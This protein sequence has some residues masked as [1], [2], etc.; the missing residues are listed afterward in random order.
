MIKKTMMSRMYVILIAIVVLVIVGCAK[1]S[2][3]PSTEVIETSTGVEFALLSPE[4]QWT[5]MQGTLESGG[6]LSDG[7]TI[8]LEK[9]KVCIGIPR[10]KD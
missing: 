4:L 1:Q 9:L 7:T 6:N 3:K 5:P 2:E 8:K 10:S